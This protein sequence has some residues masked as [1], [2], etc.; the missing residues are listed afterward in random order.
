M[1][2]I[3]RMVGDVYGGI[4]PG[5]FDVKY[6]YERV[7]VGDDDYASIRGMGGAHWRLSLRAAK[8]SPTIKVMQGT[9]LALTRAIVRDG[10]TMGAIRCSH[11]NAG[12][13]EFAW[14]IGRW[15]EEDLLKEVSFLRAIH[16][17]DDPASM[18]LIYADWLAEHDRPEDE[19][20][21]R[22]AVEAA[23]KVEDLFVIVELRTDVERGKDE[24]IEDRMIRCRTFW[25]QP[26]LVGMRGQFWLRIKGTRKDPGTGSPGV[27]KQ[28]VGWHRTAPPKNALTRAIMKD[29]MQGRLRWLGVD[30]TWTGRILVRP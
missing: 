19:Q 24:S 8:G 1:K 14:R 21:E 26:A 22:E 12:R 7:N 18:R 9:M 20:A 2:K 4:K 29:P 25:A 3:V 30:W 27:V 16:T 10:R 5:P 28:V 17:S 23:T 15:S 11:G 6:A 13:Y